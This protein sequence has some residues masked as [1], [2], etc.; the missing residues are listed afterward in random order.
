MTTIRDAVT[1]I[2]GWQNRLR[3]LGIDPDADA[4]SIAVVPVADLAECESCGHRQ[5]EP[6]WCHQCGRRTTPPKWMEGLLVVQ[7][8]KCP[9]C[10]GDGVVRRSN[11][12]DRFYVTEPCPTCHGTGYVPAEWATVDACFDWLRERGS[13][14]D[15]L[16]ELLRSCLVSRYPFHAALI[17]TCVGVQEAEDV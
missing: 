4:D 5:A 8:P 6:N 13:R 9:T 7:R 3:F 15:D 2:V 14:I 17:A 1:G 16:L 11:P 10:G 12:D